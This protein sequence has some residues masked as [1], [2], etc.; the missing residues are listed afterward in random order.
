MNVE[1]KLYKNRYRV[2][3]ERPHITI[4]RDLCKKCEENSCLYCCPVQNYKRDV[5]GDLVFSWIGCVEC[6]SCRI[7][8]VKGAIHWDYPRGGFGVCFRYG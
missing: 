7:A 5:E 1:D 4:N 8:C 3:Q 2:D 6:G